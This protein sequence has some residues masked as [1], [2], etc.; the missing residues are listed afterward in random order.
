[1][2]TSREWM[3]TVINRSLDAFAKRQRER[4]KNK[5]NEESDDSV[6]SMI[7]LFFEHSQEDAA[8]LRAEDMVDFMLTLVLTAEDT[9]SI[10]LT[11]FF[12]MLAK[13]PEVAQRVR[14][15]M[16][17]VLPSL[18]VTKDTYITTDHVNRL[19]YL[20]ATILEILRLHTTVPMITRVAADD[21]IVCGDVL[22]RKGE[23]VYVQSYAMARNPNVWGPDAAEFKP[24]RWIDP[25]TRELLKFPPTKFL[26]FGAGPHTCIGMKLAMMELRV[27]TANFVHRYALSLAV[28]NDGDYRPGVTLLMKNPLLMKVEHATSV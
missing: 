10:A 21:T 19:V 8:G 6:K 15:E 2:A 1:M 9:S 23:I 25:T 17:T 5:E 14:Q 28:P 11:R 24:E 20:E 12:L 3:Q 4:T 16:A 13:H 7:E 26:A 22:V 27:V 18:G